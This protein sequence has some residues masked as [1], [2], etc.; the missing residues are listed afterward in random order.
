MKVPLVEEFDGHRDVDRSKLL[1][2]DPP[3]Q[4]FIE[5]LESHQGINGDKELQ[6]EKT[7]S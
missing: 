1:E 4:M 5:M 2:V 6:V 7:D 3:E